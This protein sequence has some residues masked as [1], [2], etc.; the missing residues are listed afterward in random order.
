MS[1]ATPD[2]T[3]HII[4]HYED[5]Y[6][7]GPLEHATHA[8]E[9]SNP[10]CGDHVRVELQIDR[11][12]HVAE[13]WYQADGCVL[14]QASASMLMEKIEGM[15]IEDVLSYS[16]NDMLELLGTPVAPSRQRCCLL[17]WRV[18]QR[19]VQ[20]PIADDDGCNFGGPSLSE[21]C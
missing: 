4:D 7:Q 5:P 10:L 12:E 6:H 14:N 20:T 13:A 19:A 11:D 15:A 1:D 18:L 16:A 8:E 2:L 9:G 3:D 21:E 17:A